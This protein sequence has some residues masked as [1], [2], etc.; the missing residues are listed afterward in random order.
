MRMLML[1]FSIS[2]L[3]MTANILL[4]FRS[5][6]DSLATRKITEMGKVILDNVS[7][8]AVVSESQ[9]AS[10]KENSELALIVPLKPDTQS[11]FV[12]EL[13]QNLTAIADF[14]PV[15]CSRDDAGFRTAKKES[16]MH[17]LVDLF[18]IYGKLFGQVL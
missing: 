4:S 7:G 14:P 8:V 15:E 11:D 2:A 5:K 16:Y 10:I 3:L 1:P 6:S 9:P 17:S 13:T 12:H 18:P